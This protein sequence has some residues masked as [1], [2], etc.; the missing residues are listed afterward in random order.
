KTHRT[1]RLCIEKPVFGLVRR[2]H[3]PRAY[4]TICMKALQFPDRRSL[5][6]IEQARGR[7]AIPPQAP[8]LIGANPP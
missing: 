1:A 8:L 4:R 3:A 5:I 2:A 7:A 6:K